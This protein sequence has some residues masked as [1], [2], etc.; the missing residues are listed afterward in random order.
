[1]QDQPSVSTGP[2][3]DVVCQI[4]ENKNPLGALKCEKCGSNLTG[5]KRGA[6]LS[7]LLALVAVGNTLALTG[8]LG[9][10]ATNPA[11]RSGFALAG[12][13][14]LLVLVSSSLLGIAGTWHWRRWGPYLIL[15]TGIFGVVIEVVMGLF[16]P[17][18]V[19]SIALLVAIGYACRLQWSEFR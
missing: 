12:L 5:P 19:V 10:L 17:K 3:D 1:M 11:A 4:C 14:F 15:G 6:L 2:T 7:F 8:I 18:L 13:L 16:S 9:R